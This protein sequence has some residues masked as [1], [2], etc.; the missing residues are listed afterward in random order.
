[1]SFTIAHNVK[2]LETAVV[3]CSVN[4]KAT[5]YHLIVN[6]YHIFTSGERT[7]EAAVADCEKVCASYV[8]AKAAGKRMIGTNRQID[9]ALSRPEGKQYYTA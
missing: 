3:A 2:A 4:P 7:L 8:K 5:W 1:M 9:S 6:G